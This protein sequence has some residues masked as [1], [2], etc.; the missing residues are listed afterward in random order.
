MGPDGRTLLYA[1]GGVAFA[2]SH[3]DAS[4]NN[5]FDGGGIPAV[6]TL[7][8][9]ATTTGWTVGIGVERALTPAWSVKAEYDYLDF[10]RF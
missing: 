3:L 2:H 7:A 8:S 5:Q 4:V 1:K 9:S 6:T 10:G